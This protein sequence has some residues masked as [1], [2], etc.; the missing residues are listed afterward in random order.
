MV[1]IVKGVVSA[2]IGFETINETYIALIPKKKTLDLS[3][4]LDLLACV[5]W[6]IRLSPK[7]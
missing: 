2:G 3:L 1:S 7:C 5:M 4:N 6:S